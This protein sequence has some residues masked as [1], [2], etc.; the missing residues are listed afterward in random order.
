MTKR[1]LEALREEILR[2]DRDIVE[3][4]LR[5]QEVADGRSEGRRAHGISLGL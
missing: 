2:I 1:E 4:V 3:L 5:R